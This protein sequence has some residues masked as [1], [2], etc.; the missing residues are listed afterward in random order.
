MKTMA[1]IE[2]AALTFVAGQEDRLRAFYGDVLGFEEVPLPDGL[3]EDIGWIWFATDEADVFLHFI[4]HEIA[5]D[6]ERR[7]HVAFEVDSLGP[8]IERLEAAGVGVQTAGVGIPGRERF[9]C[10][11]PLGNLLEFLAM[12][13]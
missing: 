4:P 6:P 13:G 1:R 12:T 5:P 11:D 2:H 8:V 10:H 9:F 3:P 7:H